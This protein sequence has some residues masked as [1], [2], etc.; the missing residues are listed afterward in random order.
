MKHPWDRRL[1]F[2]YV[3]QDHPDLP[4][5][6]ACPSGI[7]LTFGE[8]AGRA[9]Q[10]VHALRT[11][12][13]GPGEVF[14]YVL[15]NDVDM[16]IWQ[17]AAQ[18]GGYQSIAVNPALSGAEIQRIVDHSGASAIVLHSDLADRVDKLSGTGS[19][20]LRVSI[21]GAI[22]GW[23][24]VDDLTESQP[25]T[26]PTDRRLGLP[27]AY[28]SGTTG[29]PKAVVRPPM[30]VADPSV[31][32]DT[33]KIFGRAFQFQPLTGVHLVS[34]GMHHGG[35]QSFFHGALHVGQAL[36]ILGK[37][38]PEQTLAAIDRYRVTTA[39]MVPTQFVRLLRLPQETKD[40]YDISS[41]EVVVH[42][43]AP[44]PIEVKKQMMEW[45]GPVIWETYG[46]MEGAATIA[47]PYR[48][49]EKPG[50]V[51]RS[52][53]GMTV[54]ILDEDGTELP[55]SQLGNVYLEPAGGASFAYKDDPELT[56]SVRRGQAFTLGDV[57]YLDEDGYL[58]I[59][60]RAKDMIISGG[61]NIFPAEVE[62]VLSEHPAVGDVAVIGVP[63][64]EWGEQVKAIVE[65]VD[66]ETPSDELGT[67]LIAF[68]QERMARYK[69][70]RTV[71][72]KDHLPRTDGGKLYKRIL[73]DEYWATTERRV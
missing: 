62:G 70:P 46:G 58:F 37:F 20:T 52:V 31:A 13:I 60:D 39:Y 47:K 32:A 71:D 40:R 24:S 33:M 27:I 21:G 63:D 8:L 6:V 51:G 18:E 50:T 49:L 4:A 66:G 23:T 45:W 36:V 68:C 61:V 5:V 73:R 48:W 65:L 38:D 15:P 54:K 29:Q 22:P 44:C 28:S 56:A 10:L 42:S 72:F 3:A 17:L 64:S 67:Q 9:H 25:S 1:G 69:C 7:T 12:G 57:G 53:V 55:R 30:S 2:W 59:R 14:A 11:C 26:E 43:A 41:L 34:A 16:L 19:I 35:C